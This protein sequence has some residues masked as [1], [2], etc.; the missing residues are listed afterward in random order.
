MSSDLVRVKPLGFS[1]AY[2]TEMIMAIEWPARLPDG[3]GLR[4]LTHTVPA[5]EGMGMEAFRVLKHEF[6]TASRGVNGLGL[7]AGLRSWTNGDT[8]GP[9]LQPAPVLTRTACAI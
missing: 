6:R 2:L 9:A 5:V 4:L 7:L 1:N 3:T 8:T